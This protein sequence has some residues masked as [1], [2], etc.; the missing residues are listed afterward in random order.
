MPQGWGGRATD[1]GQGIIYQ[2][3]DATGNAEAIR[4]MGPT[5]QYPRGYV[6]YYNSLGQPLDTFG[7]QEVE[8]RH[9][10]LSIMKDQYPHGH[11]K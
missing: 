6:R 11:G 8:P 4:I 2:R 10:F 3:P 9:I 5:P 7:K 1:H